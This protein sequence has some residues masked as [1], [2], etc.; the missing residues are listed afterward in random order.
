[1]RARIERLGP[2][3]WSELVAAAND[4]FYDETGGGAGRGGGD[5]VTS[6]EVGPLF[7]AVVAQTVD[8]WWQATGSPDV[9]VVVE[10]G[11]GPGTLA[12]SVLAARPACAPALRWV[13]VERSP[14]QR[15]RH[16]R[17][18]S[19]EEPAVALPPDPADDSAVPAPTPAPDG[20]IVVS[21]AALPRLARPCLVLANELLDDLPFD[22]WEARAGRWGE[23][24]IGL[25]GAALEEI[26]VA[27]E[28]PTW[29]PPADDLPDGARVPV[30]AAA[31]AWLRDALALARPEQGGR[32]VALDYCST[33]PELARRPW[34]DWVRT[35][36][37]HGRAGHPLV[38]VGT[39]NITCEVAID[40]LGRVRTPD[41]DVA[42]CDWLGAH[43]LAAL[44]AEAEAVDPARVVAGE[45][46]AIRLRSRLTEAAALTDPAG[47][48]AFRVLQWG[49]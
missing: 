31:G 27:T 32:V 43:G 22:L 42:Q 11:A 12:R 34:P 48:G 15:A 40:Q 36:A 5:F 28:P 19:L 26:L 49:A 18:L 47:L 29:L 46:A 33:T 8:D 14:G 16:G 10:A 13:L 41:A 44:V 24:R 6:P 35:Y 38:E 25:A 2:R 20:P 3:P 23:V 30:Q 37:A 45:L 21:L 1:M 7:G 17:Y 9:A 4:A 39:A